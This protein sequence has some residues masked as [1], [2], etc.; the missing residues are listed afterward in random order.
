MNDLLKF[1][2]IG[3]GGYFILKYLGILPTTT[4]TTTG[5]TGNTT[6]TQTTNTTTVFNT[7]TLALVA[8]KANDSG[9]DPNSLQTFDTWNYFYA[10]VRGIEGPDPSVY[11]SAANRSMLMSINEWAGYMAKG[12]FSGMGLIAN[13][14]NPYVTYGRSNFGDN[15]N[16]T[17]VELYRKVIGG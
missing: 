12:G 2:L 11:L 16:P 5:T 10:N 8:K 7:D 13:Y 4:T 3:V 6:S 15:L 14:V 1:G 17:G 9:T